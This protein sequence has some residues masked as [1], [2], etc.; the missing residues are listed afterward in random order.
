MDA[1][2]DQL[3]PLDRL[4]LIAQDEGATRERYRILAA[5]ARMNFSPYVMDAIVA[6]I[7]TPPESGVFVPDAPGSEVAA[8]PGR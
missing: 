4:V 5:L 2:E 7:S 8:V 1:Y 6:A 3:R